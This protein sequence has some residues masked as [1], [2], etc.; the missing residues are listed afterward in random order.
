MTEREFKQKIERLHN[1]GK[2]WPAMTSGLS[3]ANTHVDQSIG[4]ALFNIIYK[5]KEAHSFFRDASVAE[6]SAYDMM[7]SN[8]TFSRLYNF[9][10]RADIGD[11]I[12]IT[13]TNENASSI[14]VVQD[15]YS[16]NLELRQGKDVRAI[17]YR[18]ADKKDVLGLNLDTF[19]P[20]TASERSTKID[21]NLLPI[22]E[23]SGL[24]RGMCPEEQTY[25]WTA[26]NSAIDLTLTMRLTSDDCFIETDD[27]R[28]YDLL[29]ED[30]L[31][32]FCED[33]PART[34]EFVTSFDLHE[35]AFSQWLRDREDVR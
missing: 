28:N 9:L 21:K 20:L 24:L 14:G 6:Q 25:W 5:D 8:E 33:F 35:K 3:H 17:F 29:N 23:R 1:E 27:G 16:G 34:P 26:A 7:M 15:S 11:K 13:F 18:S 31:D 19:Y 4:G 30:D 32:R 12:A 22:L 10:Q 2:L